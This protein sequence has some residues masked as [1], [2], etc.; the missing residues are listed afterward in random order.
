MEN[1]PLSVAARLIALLLCSLPALAAEGDAAAADRQQ[2]LDRAAALKTDAGARQQRADALLEQRQ[3]DC[4]KRFFVNSCRDEAKAEHLQSTLEARRL[5]GEADTLE[6]EARR[7]EA[8]ERERLRAAE[9]A[10]KETELAERADA[11][12]AERQAADAARDKRRADKERR[13]AEGARRKAEEA[14]KQRRKQA[15]HEARVAKK[16]RQ[17]EQK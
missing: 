12:A 11:V 13:A 17:A 6:R 4:A 5:E 14:D 2:R 8:A 7:E 16:K 1:Q 9:A 10:R 15:E 3:L